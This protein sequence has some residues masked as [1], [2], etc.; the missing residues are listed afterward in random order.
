ME[1]IPIIGVT[2]ATGAGKGLVCKILAERGA[3]VIN[4]DII[5]HEVIKKGLPAYD[6]I[7]SAF[8]EYADILDADGEIIRKRLGEIAFA[9]EA[10][11]RILTEIT[12]KH[13]IEEITAKAA[14][15]RAMPENHTSIVIDAPLLIES[16]LHKHCNKI[17]GV[18]ANCDLRIARIMRRDGLTEHEA[19][20]RASKQ[21]PL[22][23]LRQHADV[24][25]ENNGSEAQ[26]RNCMSSIFPSTEWCQRS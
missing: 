19:R 11:L 7:L 21:T 23:T 17:I 12:H 3:F 10:K 20:L 26:L 24:I 8:S 9:D 2:G 13:I 16:G 25:V 18:A 15:I 4:A 22:E 6:E 14:K 1:Q 5:A